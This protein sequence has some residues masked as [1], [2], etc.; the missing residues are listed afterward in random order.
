MPLFRI[1]GSSL[2]RCNPTNFNL[3]KDL[4][5]LVESNLGTIFNCRFIASEFST[6]S[7]HAGRIDTLA[8]SEDN[9]PVILEYKKVESSE[10]IT[11]SLYYL[12]WIMDHRGDYCVAV[13]K[14]LGDS[15]EID[16]GDVRVICLA[17][18]YKKY[19]LHA[20]RA[21]GASIELWQYKLYE[22]G[23]FLIEEV[24]RRSAEGQSAVVEGNG[25]N[26]VMVAAGKKGALTRATA[27]YKVEDHLERAGDKIRPVAEKLRE[28]IQ[29]ISEVVEENPKKFYIAYKTTQN[30]AC[31]E[32]QKSKI[33]VF[34]KIDPKSMDQLPEHCRDVSAIGHYGTGDLEVTI[35]SVEDVDNFK[36]LIHKAFDNVGGA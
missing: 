26:P 32:I 36:G 15:P 22:D 11:Q 29:S 2:Q 19:D 12:N 14:A 17:P 1:N 10:L 33:L 24:Y 8:L 9:N 34:L 28:Q 21:M 6:G 16:W 7:V 25:K 13:N 23:T 20:V 4:Q 35:R 31:V 27:T 18:G 30:F 3:E 5:K